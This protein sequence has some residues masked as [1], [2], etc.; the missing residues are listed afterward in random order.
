MNGENMRNKIILIFAVVVLLLV[1]V[2]IFQDFFIP[3]PQPGNPYEY[4]LAE[5]KTAH[6]DVS[7]YEEIMSIEP[8][9]EKLLGI[10][11]DGDNQIYV[12]G[13]EEVLIY[14]WQGELK[15]GFELNEDAYCLAIDPSGKLFLGLPGHIEI[16]DHQGN[17]LEEW[18]ALSDTSIITSIAVDDKDV[19]IADAGSKRVYRFNKQGEFINTLGVKDIERGM[20]GF[21][22]PSPYFDLLI[23]REGELWVVN[24]GRHQL[25]AYRKDGS[26][27]SSWKKSSM[28]PEGF[29]GCCNPTHIAMLSNG[30]F[31]TSEKGIERVKIHLPSGAFDEMV[32]GPN[33]FTAGTKDLDLAVDSNDRVLVMDPY[34]GLIRIFVKNEQE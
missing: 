3:K 12:S 16:W 4:D 13:K 28:Q 25:E 6:Q 32:A 14:N 7:A 34:R 24:P 26:L 1:L 22:I 33:Q 5:F 8:A 18:P 27:I 19:F 11:V 31:V 30:S 9:T 10:A 23:G 29:C 21:I 15:G 17:L 20:H 2:F